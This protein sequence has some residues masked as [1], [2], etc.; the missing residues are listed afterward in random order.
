M[1]ATDFVLEKTCPEEDLKFEKNRASL[2]NKA[3]VSKPKN[4]ARRS[5]K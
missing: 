5:L 4:I 2:T 1:G 3:S